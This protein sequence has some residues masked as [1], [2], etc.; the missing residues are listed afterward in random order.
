MVWAAVAASGLFWGLKLGASPQAAPPQTQ[1]AGSAAPLRS[2]LTRLLGNDPPPVAPTVAAAPAP[3]TRF[4]LLGVVSPRAGGGGV[5]LIAVDGK[6]ARAFKVGAAVDGQHV[7]QT[8][9]ARGATLGPRGG[10]A[11][12]ALNIPPPPAAN[13]GTLPS[14]G[15]AGPVVPP[16]QPMA[17]PLPGVPVQPPAQQPAALAQPLP[18]QAGQALP[19]NIQ[20]LPP[21]VVLQ[22]ALPAQPVPQP[23][24]PGAPDG[25][26][27]R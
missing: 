15:G 21:N 24:R 1:V 26:A 11:T 20:T 9:S 12:I 19:P 27:L 10:A 8:V 5:A 2:D 17:A 25:A 13:T 23:G 7:L 16:P 14:A 4:S 6:P 3:D 18:V 22:E